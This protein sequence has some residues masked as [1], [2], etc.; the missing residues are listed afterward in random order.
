MKRETFV[1]AQ[2]Y[3]PVKKR[4]TID[5][6]VVREIAESILEV[7][8]QTPILVRP[9]VDRYVLVEGL[10]RIEAFKALG[11]ETIMGF[12]VSAHANADTVKSPYETDLDALRQKTER[13]RQLRLA[14]EALERATAQEK[15][16]DS[17][18]ER[19]RNQAASRR[20]ETPS[21]ADWLAEREHYGLRK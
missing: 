2:I 12:V 9:D 4:G 7:G 19:S 6:E 20:T 5:P 18:Q 11:E 3:V 14:K 15:R 17:E 10:H 16:S 21:L 8:Q 1:I 13:L